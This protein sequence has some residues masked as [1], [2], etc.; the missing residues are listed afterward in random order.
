MRPT[1]HPTV[2]QVAVVLIFSK[3]TEIRPVISHRTLVTGIFYEMA[4]FF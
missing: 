1:C 4:I 3:F 2:S